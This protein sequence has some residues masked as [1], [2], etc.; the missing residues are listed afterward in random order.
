MLS[1]D[2]DVGAG[3]ERAGWAVWID[4]FYG[5]SGINLYV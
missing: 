5:G 3:S 1:A 4:F 2:T